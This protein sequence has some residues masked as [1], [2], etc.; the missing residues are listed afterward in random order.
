MYKAEYK[1]SLWDFLIQQEE[2]SGTLLLTEG[3]LQRLSMN[4]RT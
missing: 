4:L 3:I 2:K 1:G